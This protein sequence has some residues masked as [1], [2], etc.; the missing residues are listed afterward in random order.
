M[1]DG[2]KMQEVGCGFHGLLV[3]FG[4]FL[5]LRWMIL[6]KVQGCCPYLVSKSSHQGGGGLCRWDI[7]PSAS[8]TAGGCRPGM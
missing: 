7:L 1:T 4:V 5:M 2:A 8:S 3:C 6:K